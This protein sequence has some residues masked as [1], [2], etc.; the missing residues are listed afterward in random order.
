MADSGNYTLKLNKTQEKAPNSIVFEVTSK[1]IFTLELPETLEVYI[2]EPMKLE[3]KSNQP[4]LVY[5]WFKDG[6][7]L[8]QGR[9]NKSTYVYSIH[10]ESAQRA[11]DQGTV[12]I[13]TAN[14]ASECQVVVEEKPLRFLTE[15]DAVKIK[16]LPDFARAPAGDTEYLNEAKFACELSRPYTDVTWLVNNTPV[17]VNGRYNIEVSNDS[18]RHSLVIRD[19]TLVDSGT[20][21]QI[22]LNSVDKISIAKLKVEQVQTDALAKLR[23]CLEDAKAKETEPATFITEI[24]LSPVVLNQL[25]VIKWLKDGHELSSEEAE[26][27][28]I[29]KEIDSKNVLKAKLTI[30][31][32]TVENDSGEYSCQLI[33]NNEP[34]DVKQPIVKLYIKEAEPYLIK[35]LPSTVTLIEGETLNLSAQISKTGL[36]VEWLKDNQSIKP[37]LLAETRCELVVRDCVQGEDDATYE[38]RLCDQSDE[39]CLL[40]LRTQLSVRPFGVKIADGLANATVVEGDVA[41]LQFR[42][43]KPPVLMSLLSGF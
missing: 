1:N 18:L 24:Q 25:I 37:L 34:I 11:R 9:V 15:L 8:C 6:E 5:K 10:V 14:S 2:D 29:E 19:C 23:R 4:L 17:S 30:K 43:S 41:K 32:C 40:T 35:E 12:C 33:I 20:S 27:Y 36:T 21:V 28:S 16:L 7:K 38:L 26:K 31:N 22:R 39:T 42:V 3:V 13:K